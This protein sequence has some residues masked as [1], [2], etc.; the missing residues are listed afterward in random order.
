[1]NVYFVRHGESEGNFKKTHQGS[2]VALSEKGKKQARLVAERLKGIG[3][4]VIYAS[5]FRR[6]RQTAETIAK[7]LDLPIEYWDHLK[8]LKRP[9]ELE[10]LRYSDPKA[11]AIKKMIY[12][13][14]PKTDWK[15]SDDESFDDLLT[16]ARQ[17][18]KHLFEHHRDQN[19][20]CVSHIQI[21][22]MVVL[23]MILQDKLT[24]EVFWQFYYHC[25]QKNTGI[26]HLKYTETF[27]W[28]LVTWNDTTHL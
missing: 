21:M 18:E 9:S 1:M 11:K 28:N 26:T 2:D 5:P 27:G 3:I 23:Q 16:R 12:Q 15:F 17:V 4:D 8:E 22:V 14:Q 13:N 7:E 24:S 10:G 6:T 20:L 25:R 19:V